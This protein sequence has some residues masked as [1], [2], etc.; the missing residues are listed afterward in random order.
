VAV[1]ESGGNPS[2]RRSGYRKAHDGAFQV[3]PRY[4]GRVPKDAKGQAKQ[5]DKILADLLAAENTLV[6]ALNF[7]GGESDKKEGKYAFNILNELQ[8]V[9]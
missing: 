2:I 8:R 7:Y 5:A 4:W 1:V 9:P 3:N 6:P